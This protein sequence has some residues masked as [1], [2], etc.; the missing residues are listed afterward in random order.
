MGTLK[1]FSSLPEAR[2]TPFQNSIL[3]LLAEAAG[4]PAALML[5]MLLME[6]V[7]MQY[8]SETPADSA[9]QESSGQIGG[10]GKSIPARKRHTQ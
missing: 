7:L 6:A 9:P 3:T 4:L 10:N 1:R 8:M 5:D 2:L